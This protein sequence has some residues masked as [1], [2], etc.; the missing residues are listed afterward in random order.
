[1]EV[2]TSKQTV[3]FRS[4]YRAE[5]YNPLG[6]VVE[7][8]EILGNVPDVLWHV[9]RKVCPF[10]SEPQTPEIAGCNVRYGFEDHLFLCNVANAP[11]LPDAQ[12]VEL[13]SEVEA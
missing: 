5:Y 10:L 6:E 7:V 9:Y 11:T 1:M 13:L 8:E 12:V 4:E 2:K 3:T